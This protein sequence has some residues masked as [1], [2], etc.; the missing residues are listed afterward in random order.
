MAE[1]F[2]WRNRSS[3]RDK[4]VSLD[5]IEFRLAVVRDVRGTHAVVE[6]IERKPNYPSAYKISYNIL[7]TQSYDP[8]L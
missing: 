5:G 2:D 7:H 8:N 4:V 6:S 3:V 1:G